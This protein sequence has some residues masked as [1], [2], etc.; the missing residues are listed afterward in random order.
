MKI[1]LK[2]KNKIR[3]PNEEETPQSQEEEEEISQIQE[4]KIEN[5]IK[6]T[7]LRRLSRVAQDSTRL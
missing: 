4:E 2:N 5:G 3:N 7:S 6:E 1:E